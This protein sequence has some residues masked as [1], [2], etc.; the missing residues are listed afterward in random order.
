M[1]WFEKFIYALQ[2]EIERPKVFGW[3]HI[4]AFLLTIAVSALV[5]VFRKKMSKKFINVSLLAVGIMLIIIEG[6]KQVLNALDVVDGV[7]SWSYSWRTFP[8]QFCSVPMYVMFIAG[9]LR[10]GKVY[11][12]LL[13]FLATFGLFGGLIT[14]VYPSTVFST[15]LYISLHTMIWHGSMVVVGIMLLATRSVEIKFKTVFKACIIFLI[16]VAMAEI[17]NVIWHFFGTEKEFNMLYISPYYE[18]DLPVF[19]TIQAKAPYAVFLLSYIVGF[20]LAAIIVMASAIGIDKLNSR[21]NRNK[22]DEAKL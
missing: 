5:I 19:K 21:I 18:S 16:I 13:C 2:F 14:V 10:K 12:T 20:M 15:H 4:T 22:S 6:L 1:N 17:M 9:I 8:F 11:N 3:F 7:A